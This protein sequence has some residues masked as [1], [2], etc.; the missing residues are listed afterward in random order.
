MAVL[1]MLL[2]LL[3]NG[4]SVDCAAA[5]MG[6]QH[7]QHTARIIRHT[8]DRTDSL[9]GLYATTKL[10]LDESNDQL[11]LSTVGSNPLSRSLLQEPAGTDAWRDQPDPTK[12]DKWD[13]EPSY[14]SHYSS[15]AERPNVCKVTHKVPAPLGKQDYNFTANQKD[16]VPYIGTSLVRDSQLMLMRLYYRCARVL[17]A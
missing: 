16:Y 11:R 8:Q 17:H 1:L 3:Y 10:H 9:S 2:L 5:E 6:P 4:H 14:S 7:M 15:D 13:A 12:R